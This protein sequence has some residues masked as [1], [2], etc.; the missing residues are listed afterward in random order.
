MLRWRIA[1]LV[2]VAIV[3][4]YLDRLTLPWTLSEI[5]QEYPFSDQV[6]ALFDSAFLISYCTS[7]AR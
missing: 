5:Q 6:K 1:I 7:I 3:L 4:S 2:S